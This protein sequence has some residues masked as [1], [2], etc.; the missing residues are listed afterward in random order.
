MFLPQFLTYVAEKEQL[1]DDKIAPRNCRLH[2]VGVRIRRRGRMRVCEDGR[3]VGCVK[4]GYQVIVAP[5]L[6]LCGA[7]AAQRVLLLGS[8]RLGSA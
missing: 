4:P 5:P 2:G 6:P 1:R 7:A 3:R 8:A